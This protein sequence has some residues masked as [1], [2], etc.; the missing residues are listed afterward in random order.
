MFRKLV[1]SRNRGCIEFL[2]R[3]SYMPEKNSHIRHELEPFSRNLHRI[4]YRP[5]SHYWLTPWNPEV[6]CWIHK[7]SQIIHI[8]S[9]INP[10]P[11]FDTY[12]CKIHSNIVLP[13]MPKPFYR[14]PPYRFNWI[15]PWLMKSGG[16]KQHSQGF[17]NNPNPE[18]NQPSSSLWHLFL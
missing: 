15:T 17:S 11:R 10:I 3:A 2:E 12:F 16:W 1:R 4:S 14:S 5:G 6:E 7:G 13:S 18:P 9:R 8:L